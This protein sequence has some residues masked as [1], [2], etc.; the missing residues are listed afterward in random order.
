MPYI[1]GLTGGIGSGKSTVAELFGTLG[2]TVIDSDAI[3]HALTAPGGSAM[4]AIRAAFGD[5][6]DRCVE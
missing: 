3:A 4:Q 5:D 2:A 6:F 1:I